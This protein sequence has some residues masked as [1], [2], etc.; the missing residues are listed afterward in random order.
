MKRRALK[1]ILD[2][3]VAHLESASIN[4][5]ITL[6]EALGNVLPDPVDRAKA[7]EIAVTLSEVA[8]LQLDFTRQLFNS[9]P[10]D[11]GPSQG[12]RHKS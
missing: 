10:K 1:T 3:V 12:D 4:D 9:P 11:D 7:T 2:W 6:Y 8:K 5:Q